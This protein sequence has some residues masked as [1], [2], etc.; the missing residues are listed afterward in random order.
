MSTPCPLVSH[1]LRRATA[2]CTLALALCGLQPQAAKS[3]DVPPVQRHVF[4]IP[5]GKPT[6]IARS[7]RIWITVFRPGIPLSK[8]RPAV[9]LLHPLGEWRNTLMLDFGRFLAKRGMIAAVLELPFHMRRL[10]PRD[11]PLSHYVST[12]INKVHQ[13][14]SQAIEDA[15]AVADWLSTQPDVDPQHI[16][17]IGVSLGAIVTHTAM[18]RDSRF[19]AGVAILGGA[20]FPDLYRRSVLFRLLH[21]GVTRPL[22]EREVILLREIDPLTYA[23][24]NRPRHVL[25]IQAA[26]DDV[27]PAS[28]ATELWKALGR[29]PIRWL[30]TNHYGPVFN[31]DGIREYAVDYL[32]REWGLPATDPRPH[33]YAPTLKLSLLSGLDAPLSAGLEWQ[34]VSFLQRPNHMSLLHFDLGL[35]NRGPYFGFAGTVNAYL[36]IGYGRRFG[37]ASWRPYLSLHLA[38]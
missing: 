18:G 7:D 37:R 20:G 30:D 4:V 23:D 9:V 32:R 6:G 5:S 17:I 25:M 28:N 26:R 34:A 14:F 11:N 8:P 3:Q 27:I 22:T 1:I 33:I 19:S 10:P 2:V 13:A 16:G 12:D 21:P 15:R 38:L 24:R 35:D 31:A 36:D 29:P